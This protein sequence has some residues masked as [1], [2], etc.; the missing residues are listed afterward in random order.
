MDGVVCARFQEVSGLDA[1]HGAPRTVLMFRRGAISGPALWQWRREGSASQRDGAL[2]MLDGSGAVK[3]RWLFRAARIS[4]WVGPDL[5][6]KGG[7]DVEM[8]TLELVCEGIDL[9]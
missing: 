7:A 8:R 5:Q 9:A 6:A 1:P 2:A 4:K 3:A